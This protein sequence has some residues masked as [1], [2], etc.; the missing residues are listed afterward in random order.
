V[1]RARDREAPDVERLTQAALELH[2]SSGHIGS[3]E[4]EC[5]AAVRLLPPG[6]FVPDEVVALARSGGP[7]VRAVVAQALL[8]AGATSEARGLLEPGPTPGASDY[9]VQAA[10]CLRVLV[11]AAIGRPDEL[12]DAV[13]R[14]EPYAGTVATYGTVDHL[15]ATDYFLGVGHHALGDSRAAAE[16][17][18]AVELTAATGVLPWHRRAVAL[19][20]SLS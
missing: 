8:D 9:S 13:A 11:L 12:A 1:A 17:A 19:L 20:D 15:G 4:L 14:L 3:D 10:L 18:A 7:A 2:R 6:G 16:A 5:L